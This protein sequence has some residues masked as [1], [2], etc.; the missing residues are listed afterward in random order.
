MD[1]KEF[2]QFLSQLEDILWYPR[3][4]IQSRNGMSWDDIPGRKYFSTAWMDFFFG[5][6]D[7]AFQGMVDNLINGSTIEQN[8]KEIAERLL[9]IIEL[10]E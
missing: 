10:L 6:N 8:V 3:V 1:M 5:I 2:Q 9:P 4:F 7:G